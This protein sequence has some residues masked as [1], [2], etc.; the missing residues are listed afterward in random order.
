MGR[1]EREGKIRSRKEEVG[2]SIGQKM[3]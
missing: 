3:I 1:I 2:C